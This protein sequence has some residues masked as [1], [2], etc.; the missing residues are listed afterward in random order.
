MTTERPS[1]NSTKIP[2]LLLK[3]KSTP[4]DAYEDLFSASEDGIQFEPT[5]VPVLQHR[6]EDAGMGIL[7]SL[8]QERRINR[9]TDSSYGGLIFTSQRAVEAFAKLAGRAKGWTRPT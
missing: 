3:T 5:F 8:L 9:S 6:F 1:A 4:G 7:N 2:I